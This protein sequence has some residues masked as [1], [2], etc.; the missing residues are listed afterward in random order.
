MTRIKFLLETRDFVVLKNIQTGCGAHHH[1][2]HHH[3]AETF[4]RS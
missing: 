1:H 4:L 3:A 2:H